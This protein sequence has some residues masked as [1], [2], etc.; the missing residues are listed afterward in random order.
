[1]YLSLPRKLGEE[2]RLLAAF[3]QQTAVPPPQRRS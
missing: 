2:Y 1:V 3:Q